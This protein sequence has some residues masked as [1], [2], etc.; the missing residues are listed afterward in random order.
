MQSSSSLDRLRD[1]IAALEGSAPAKPRSHIT[2]W[3]TGTAIGKPDM[4][5][6]MA[7][8]DDALPWG[9]LKLGALH[10]IAPAPN[11]MGGIPSDRRD[12]AARGFATH[13]LALLMRQSSKPA[14]WVAEGELPYAPGL[15]ALGLPPELLVVIKAGKPA[16]RLWALEEAT[17]SGAVAAILG[18]V[19]GVDFTGAR[20]LALAARTSGVPL[21]LLNR[22]PAP[23]QAAVTRWQIVSIPAPH[24]ILPEAIGSWRWRVE[25]A[26]CQGRGI[27]EDG[28]VAAWNVEW[29]DGTHSLR[30]VAEAGDRP[31][32][33]RIS[34]VA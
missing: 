26:F 30:L 20:R 21:L 24:S 5:R 27:G 18:E 6:I 11:P 32:Q 3:G 15:A 19:R 33:A 14:L 7:E 28:S 23:V 10:E 29:D 16:Q 17:R 12:G 9:G 34:R 22:D 2:G 31:A 4:A 13:L 25:L 1:R 8:I